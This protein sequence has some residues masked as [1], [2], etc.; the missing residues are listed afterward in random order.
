MYGVRWC[1]TLILLDVA[2][3]F[4][5]HHLLKRL[6]STVC[7]CL[8]CQRLV[9]HRCLDL[10]LGF[11]YYSID[12]YFCFV[13]L[14]YCFDNCSFVV[15]TEIRKL[16]SFVFDFFFPILLWLFMV[17]IQILKDSILVKNGLG[18]LIGT[19]LNL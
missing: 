11:L 10:F 18:N 14:S 5:Q 15:L 1:S 17:S 7:F 6:S 8:L 13:P 9:D 19:A 4:P 2:F 12:L 3:Q 16:N